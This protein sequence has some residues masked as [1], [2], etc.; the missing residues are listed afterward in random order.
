MW[1][2]GRQQSQRSVGATPIRTPEPI[3]LQSWLP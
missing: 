1:W 3:A 2:S